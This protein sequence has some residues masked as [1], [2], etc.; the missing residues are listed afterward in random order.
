MPP[1]RNKPHRKKT[2][3]RPSLSLTPCQTRGYLASTIA[4]NESSLPLAPRDRLFRVT[5]R[6]VPWRRLARDIAPGK[7]VRD[8]RPMAF[9]L[10][11]ALTRERATRVLLNAATAHQWLGGPL[12]H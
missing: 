7:V 4:P 11:A 8:G 3:A 5:M 12:E 6:P 10:V 1:H 9:L 2:V